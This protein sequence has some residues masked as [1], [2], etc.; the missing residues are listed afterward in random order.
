MNPRSPATADLMDKH[1]AL[2][3]S[4]L[5]QFRQ[6]GG[7]RA[8]S[9]PI[10]TVRCRDDNVLL[11]RALDGPGN[12]GVLVVDGGGSLE[13]ALLGDQIAGL[14]CRNGWAGIVIH[15]AVRDVSALQTMD[16]GIKALGSNPRKSAKNG[17]GETDVELRF[18]GAVFTPGHWLYSDDDG[19]LISPMKLE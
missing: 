3:Q 19:I 7:R 5:I 6:F 16:F 1:G 11:R 17:A 4:C 18:G 15:G 2:C 9:G 8:F 10:R 13:T 12:G 14:G